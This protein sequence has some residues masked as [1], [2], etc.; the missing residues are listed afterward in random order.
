MENMTNDIVDVVKD[1]AT[2]GGA[3]FLSQ[4]GVK[5]GLIGFAIGAGATIATFVVGK[6]VKKAIAK[7]QAEEQA[8]AEAEYEA[9]VDE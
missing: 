9:E 5:S 8:R 2:N 7:K 4:P 6:F 3:G 1:E